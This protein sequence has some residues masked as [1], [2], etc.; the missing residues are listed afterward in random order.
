MTKNRIAIS[1]GEQGEDFNINK[2]VEAMENDK[3]TRRAK[4]GNFIIGKGT[5]QYF[6]KQL[7]EFFLESMLDG[8]YLDKATNTTFYQVLL[9]EVEKDEDT[10]EEYVAG[11]VVSVGLATA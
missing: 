11:E 5:G 10:G 6:D 4:D 3:K 1:F 9:M 7:D 8:R 2:V